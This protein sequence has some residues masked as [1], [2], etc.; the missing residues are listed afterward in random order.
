[1]ALTRDEAAALD[2]KDPLAHFRERFT[3]A[4]PELIYLDGNSLGRLSV[5]TRER[6]HE[7][8]E[9]WGDRLVSGWHDWIDA[10]TR[11]GDLLAEAA[12]GARPGEVIVCDST[13]VNLYKLACATLDAYSLSAQRAL[14]TDRDNFPTDRYVLEGI[15]EQRG[16]ELRLLEAEDPLHGPQP[17]DLEPLLA[18]GAVALIVLSHVAYRSGAL[19]DMEALTRL[20]RDYDA[21][22]VWDLSHS[23]GAV[24]VR[25]RDAGVELAVGCTYKYLNSGPGG[26]AYLYVAEELQAGLRSPIWGWF[27][28]AE[29]F[30]MER[31]YEP[32]E[33]IGRFLAGTPPILNVAAVEAGAGLTAEAGIE[34]IREKSVAQTELVIALHDEW[35]APLGFELGT[36]RDPARRGSHVSLR[37]PEAWP[38]CRALIERAAVVPDFRGPDSIRL[39]VA[40]L[41]TSYVDVWDALDRLRGLVERGEQRAVDAA[42]ARV[43]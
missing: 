37:H 3:V 34:A 21:H 40:P 43:T 19:A 8:V 10:P 41:Y 14:V 32:A 11:A 38:I 28:Q 4:D 36:P 39:G 33:G 24:P 42:R 1:M 2:A 29:Q 23:A 15:A 30:A 7:V 6:L 31:P 20:A 16:L 25:L 17:A 12:L 9:Q 35:L 27:G 18:D 26:T 13:T 22:I 5:D